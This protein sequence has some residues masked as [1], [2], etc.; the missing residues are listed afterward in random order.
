MKKILII[1]PLLTSLLISLDSSSANTGIWRAD[2]TK[3][4]TKKCVEFN[5]TAAFKWPSSSKI[6]AFKRTTDPQS[7]YLTSHFIKK[8]TDSLIYL[9]WPYK[10]SLSINSKMSP[11]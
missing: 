5:N 3:G 10:T 7:A 1:I 11:G 6:I 9:I 4:L 8:Y 2:L